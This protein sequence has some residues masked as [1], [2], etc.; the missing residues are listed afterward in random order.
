[1]TPECGVARPGER[2]GGTLKSSGYNPLNEG[3]LFVHI[4]DCTIRNNGFGVRI[5]PD[6]FGFSNPGVLGLAARTTIFLLLTRTAFA[7]NALLDAVADAAGADFLS[8]DIVD[9]EGAAASVLEPAGHPDWITGS[10]LR[11]HGELVAPVE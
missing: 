2:Q 11:Y 1:L 7:D 9:P 10:E 8:V 6:N 5:R 3:Q 4:H